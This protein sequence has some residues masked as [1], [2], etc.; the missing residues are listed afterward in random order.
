[1]PPKS[2]KYFY[3]DL[4]KVDE[5]IKVDMSE[6]SDEK[7][8][9]LRRNKITSNTAIIDFINRATTDDRFPGLPPDVSIREEAA[10][11]T[12]EA[13]TAIATAELLLAL[14][15]AEA[16]AEAELLLALEAATAEAATAIA[17][18]EAATAI[19][20]AEAATAIATAEARN[21]TSIGYFYLE[22]ALAGRVLDVKSSNPAQG[23]ELHMW[24]KNGTQAQQFKLVSIGNTGY[25]YLENALAGL[26]LDVKSSNPAQGT[27]LH[28]QGKNGTPAQQ[29]KL[30]LAVVL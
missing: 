22:N 8:K 2:Y 28:M 21:M 9:V 18:A 19:A 30:V 1:M 16:T 27:E 17:T 25:F 12:A 5:E 24:G 26:V 20:T 4:A 14:E 11:A 23:T 6:L 15:A 10:I 29:F 7:K 13:A 3:I